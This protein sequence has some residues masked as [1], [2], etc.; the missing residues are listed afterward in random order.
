MC[1]P[2]AP[3]DSDPYTYGM[4]STTFTPYR[5]RLYSTSDPYTDLRRGDEGTVV[6]E[7]ED[8]WGDLNISV[9]WDNGSCLKLIEGH[10]QWHVI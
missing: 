6:A 1:S 8:P 5:I 9:K 7:R 4:E 10:D 3:T 2:D